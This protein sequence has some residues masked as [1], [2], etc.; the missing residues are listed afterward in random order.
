MK[1]KLVLVEEFIIENKDGFDV[2]VFAQSGKE[3]ILS[4]T[5]LQISAQLS[6]LGVE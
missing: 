3:F 5:N 1:R 4:V 6:Y 2:K